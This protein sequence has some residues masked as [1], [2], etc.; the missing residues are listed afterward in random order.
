MVVV[1]LGL[2]FAITGLYRTCG[3]P[4]WVSIVTLQFL[5]SGCAR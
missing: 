2:G 4:E 3:V 1:S 5:P